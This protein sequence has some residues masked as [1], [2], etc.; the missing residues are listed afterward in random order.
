MVTANGSKVKANGS[1]VKASGEGVKVT[2][3][4]AAGASGSRNKSAAVKDE[5]GKS[6]E[7]NKYEKVLC[8]VY[9]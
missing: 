5:R 9:R 8:I 1:K 4:R 3:G 2:N 7:C 6:G